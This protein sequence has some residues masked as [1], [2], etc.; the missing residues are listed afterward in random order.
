MMAD[1]RDLILIPL[2]LSL[3][4]DMFNIHKYDIC[5]LYFILKILTRF[6]CVSLSDPLYSIA[7]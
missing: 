5:Q 2:A 6:S 4:T 1:A 7:L 3:D